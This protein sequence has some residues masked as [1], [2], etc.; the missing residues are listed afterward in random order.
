MRFQ[1]LAFADRMTQLGSP[2]GPFEA[3]VQ[4]DGD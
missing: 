4:A 1:P 3:A 2:S